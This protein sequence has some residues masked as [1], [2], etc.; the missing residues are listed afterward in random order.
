M[1][2]WNA[3]PCI[4]DAHHRRLTLALERNGHASAGFVVFYGVVHQVAEKLLKPGRRGQNAQAGIL[5]LQIQGNIL[6]LFSK[7]KG[8]RTIRPPQFSLIFD[9]L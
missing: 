8:G 1:F 7:Y 4:L 5:H 2:R 3:D 6:F 9:Y